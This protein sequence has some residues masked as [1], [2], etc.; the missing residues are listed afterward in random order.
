MK[1]EFSGIF[2]KNTEISNFMKIRP[3]RAELLH[4]DGGTDRRTDSRDERNSP[5]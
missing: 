4:A 3:M 5:F 2:S 1:L